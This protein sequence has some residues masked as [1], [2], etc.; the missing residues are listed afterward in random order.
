[1]C[2]CENGDV[3]KWM[4]ALRYLAP[5]HPLL[6]PVCRR[7]RLTVERARGVETRAVKHDEKNT[8]QTD[9]DNRESTRYSSVSHTVDGC[10]FIQLK[11]RCT[12]ANKSTFSTNQITL[13]KTNDDRFNTIMS[14]VIVDVLQLHGFIPSPSSSLLPMHWY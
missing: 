2:D 4:S 9:Y 11:M 5:P 8:R 14:F 13:I 6:L 10:N 3:R 12:N 1:M 7:R